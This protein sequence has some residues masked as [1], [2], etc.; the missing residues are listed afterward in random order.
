[1]TLLN[2]SRHDARLHGLQHFFSR[3]SPFLAPLYI[4]FINLVYARALVPSIPSSWTHPT[5]PFL[6]ITYR[7]GHDVRLMYTSNP[8]TGHFMIRISLCGIPFPLAFQVL[9]AMSLRLPSRRSSSG[10]VEQLSASPS[11]SLALL[12]CPFPSYVI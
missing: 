4:L 11:L 9:V 2:P 6:L 3:L 5:L 12:V 8:L 1:M 10:V 7:F